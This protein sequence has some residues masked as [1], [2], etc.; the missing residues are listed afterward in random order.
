MQALI[1]AQARARAQR[2]R[3]IEGTNTS[4]QQQPVLVKSVNEDHFGYTDHVSISLVP[5]LPYFGSYIAAEK[6][7][8]EVA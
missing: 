3:M 7:N 6:L 2:I 8:W 4:Y 5:N 1:T